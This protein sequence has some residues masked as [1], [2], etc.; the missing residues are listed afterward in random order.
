MTERTTRILLDLKARQ[1]ADEHMVCPRCGADNMKHP[2]HTNALSRIAEIYICDSCGSA[3]AMLEHMNQRSPLTSW[4]VFKPKVPPS[5]F[6]ERPADEVLDLVTKTQLDALTHIFRLC[7]DDPAQAEEY[8]LEAFESCSG[9]TE[10]WTQ[11]FAAKYKAVDGSVVVR[12]TTNA[13]GNPVVQAG[14]AEK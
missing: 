3:E 13:D 5:D 8:R 14:I 9:L 6:K 4:D 2:L 12:F 10:L 11:P 7:R 1:D